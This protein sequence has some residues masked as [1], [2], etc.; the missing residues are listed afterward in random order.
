LRKKILFITIIIVTIFKLKLAGVG[1]FATADEIRYF[2][3][4]NA[5]IQLKEGNFNLFLKSIF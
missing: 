4:V 3:S 1:F 5:L 2:E